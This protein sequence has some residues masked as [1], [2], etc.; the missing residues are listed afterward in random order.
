VG[1]AEVIDSTR[2]RLQPAAG[3]AGTVEVPY[4]MADAPGDTAQSHVTFRVPF[5]GEQRTVTRQAKR[6]QAVHAASLG[7]DGLDVAVAALSNRAVGWARNNP[8]TESHFDS[9]SVLKQS[10]DGAVDVHAA[11]LT[12][13]GRP[14]VLATSLRGDAVTWYENRADSAFAG[15]QPITTAA[16][17]PVA[18]QTADVDADGDRDIIVGTVVG[19]RVLWYENEGNGEFG[20]GREIA[21]GVRV[22][23]TLHVTD[24]DNDD[25]PDLLAVSYRDSTIHRYEPAQTD[26]DSVRFVS[27]P[28]ISLQRGGPIEVHTADVTGNG[29]ADVIVGMAGAESVVLVTNQTDTTGTLHFGD[30]RRLPSD[31]ET[32]E[33]IDTGDV[34]GDGA[35]D[36]IAGS[37][38]SDSVVWFENDGSG[39]FRPA[40]PIATDVPNVL[41]LE[42]ADFNGDGAPDVAAASQ[43][44]NVVAWYENHL[45]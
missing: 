14:D 9:L 6:P 32:V 37:F 41:S 7:G 13:T 5:S 45:R 17:G 23:E 33:G 27:G 11:D 34:D 12:G 10:G 43:A 42:V 39:S 31:V 22:L 24:L 26:A 25:V 15:P 29:W 30:G 8:S 28:D 19:R 2:L 44:G 40:Q 1:Q 21:S 36:V 18:V 20:A 4:V 35:P 16:D 38:D 3:F